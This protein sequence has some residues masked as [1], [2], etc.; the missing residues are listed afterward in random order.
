M[1]YGNVAVTYT[2]CPGEERKESRRGG[3]V[4]ATWQA[5]KSRPGAKGFPV[6]G[7]MNTPHGFFSHLISHHLDPSRASSF[8]EY[9]LSADKDA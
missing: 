8:S 7:Y 5:P 9:L 4:G 2:T 1:T 6:Q 3:H